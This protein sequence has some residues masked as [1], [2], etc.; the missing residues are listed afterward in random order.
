MKALVVYDSFFGNTQKIACA[1][2]DAIGNALASQADVQT[3]RVG[4]AKPGHLTGLRLLIV[5]SP[6]RAFSASPATK[7][8]SKP[9]PPTACVTSKSRRSTPAPT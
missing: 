1:V 2:G 8:G 4:D 5:G 6:T 9:W 7:A 3:L